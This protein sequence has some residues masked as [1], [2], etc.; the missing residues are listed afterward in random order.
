LQLNKNSI[1]YPS[2]IIVR[3]VSYNV[4]GEIP[5]QKEVNGPDSRGPDAEFKVD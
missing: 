1:F 2:R 5:Q 4:P 3:L